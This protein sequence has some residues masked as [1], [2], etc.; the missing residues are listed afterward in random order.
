[1]AAFVAGRRAT[2]EGAE[3][4]PMN[5]GLAG[6]AVLGKLDHRVALVA[7]ALLENRP[8]ATDSAQVAR[9]IEPLEPG[10]RSPLFEM[11]AT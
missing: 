8:R 2:L 5:E 9:F 3:Y 10:D 1:M 4:L 7:Q 11:F 6:P